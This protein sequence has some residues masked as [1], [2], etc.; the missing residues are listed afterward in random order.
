MNS[1]FIIRYFYFIF[2]NVQNILGYKVIR[3]RYNRDFR[4][5]IYSTASEMDSNKSNEKERNRMR[6]KKVS[7]KLERTKQIKYSGESKQII[8]NVSAK[9]KEQHK[10]N[11]SYLG[12][13]E[14]LF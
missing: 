7:R 13:N 1:K 11:Y 10:E 6:Q 5:N 2:L 8:E 12:K 4:S 14:V 3:Q 9:M